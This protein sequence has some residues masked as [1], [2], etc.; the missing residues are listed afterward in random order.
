MKDVA[1]IGCFLDR[2]LDSERFKDS[3]HNGLQVQNSGRVG[4]VC[5]FL[6]SR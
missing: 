5:L 2:L 6:A 4:A 3:S 1:E